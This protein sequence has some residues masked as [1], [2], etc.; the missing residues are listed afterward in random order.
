MSA[1]QAQLHAAIAAFE[2]QRVLLGGGVDADGSIR[3]VA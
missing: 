2:G 3:G 1:G